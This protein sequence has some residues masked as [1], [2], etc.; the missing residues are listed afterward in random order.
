MARPSPQ[1]IASHLPSLSA[2]DTR[3]AALRALKNE[4]I[5]HE[6]K[7]ELWVRSGV[8]RPLRDVLDLPKRPAGI[9][10]KRH[11]DRSEQEEARLQAIIIVGSIAQGQYIIPYRLLRLELYLLLPSLGS[12]QGEGGLRKGLQERRSHCRVH[13]LGLAIDLYLS[14]QTFMP[15]YSGIAQMPWE[16]SIIAQASDVRNRRCL[17]RISTLYQR[18]STPSARRTLAK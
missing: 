17:L 16:Y 7:K 11:Q 13:A 12:L 18:H 6:E 3:L 5:G 1:S 10:P 15:C 9:T 2:P 8:L 14:W 4:L